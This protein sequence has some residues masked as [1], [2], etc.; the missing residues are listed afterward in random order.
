MKFL[1][2]SKFAKCIEYTSE[3]ARRV[4]GGR[5]PS[6]YSLTSSEVV[7]GKYYFRMKS[8]PGL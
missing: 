2:G 7:E 3:A 1:S 4:L 6:P 5:K 8:L